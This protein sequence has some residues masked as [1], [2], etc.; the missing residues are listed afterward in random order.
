[1]TGDETIDLI[2]RYCA[3]NNIFIPQGELCAFFISL[4]RIADRDNI[5][6]DNFTVV[7]DKHSRVL[8]SVV[9][10][11]NWNDKFIFIHMS[12]LIKWNNRVKVL[13]FLLKSK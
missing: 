1:M 7:I 5:A 10:Y 6:A 11:V 8:I 2:T 12:E 4:K 9:T 13:R 3:K